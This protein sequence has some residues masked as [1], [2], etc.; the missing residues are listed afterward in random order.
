MYST[1][2]VLFGLLLALSACAA[3]PRQYPAP[4]RATHSDAALP[5]FTNIRFWGDEIPPYIDEIIASQRVILARNPARGDRFDILALSGGADEGAYGAGFLRGWTERG[6]RPS[7]AIVTGVS[8]GA[9]IAPFAFLGPE[10]DDTIR[11]FYLETSRDDVLT[12]RP[13]LALAGGAA[14][15][16]VAPLRETIEEEIDAEMITKIAAEHRQ[17]R[18][19]L[20]GTTNLDAQRQVVWDIGRIAASGNPRSAELI[21]SV[22]LA[23]ASI[24]AMFPPVFIDVEIDGQRFQEMHVDGGVTHE[25][26]AYPAALDVKSL[27]SELGVTQKKTMWLIRNGKVHPSYE[28]VIPGVTDIAARSISTLIKY[29]SRGDLIALERLARRDGFDFRVTTIPDSFDMIWEDLFVPAY[30]HALYDIGYETA[31]SDRPWRHDLTGLF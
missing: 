8:T 21:R 14:V 16:D 15:G 11:R 17:G 29:Q 28:P 31:L 2:R 23:S 6:D 3:P 12:I 26:F 22:L 9:L 20:V 27:S 19:L 1:L 25:I 10:Y 13:L 7:F 4:D 24:P 5:G 30:T 18:A